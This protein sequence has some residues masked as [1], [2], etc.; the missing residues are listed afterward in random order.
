MTDKP[1]NREL[2]VLDYLCLGNVEELAAM[3]HIGM[4]TIA[5]MIQKGWIE[6]AH[7]AYYGRHGYKITQKGSEV[8]EVF[9]RRL[10]R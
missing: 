4:G 1:N 6:E 8:F 7:D 5:P 9:F 10:K 2:K 3:P